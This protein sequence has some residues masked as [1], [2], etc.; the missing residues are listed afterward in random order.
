MPGGWLN[1]FLH[2]CGCMFKE[3]LNRKVFV[4]LLRVL[5]GVFLNSYIKTHL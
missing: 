5:L 1:P 2:A 3:R 4:F